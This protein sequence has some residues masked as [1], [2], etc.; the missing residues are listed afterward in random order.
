M[1]L[2]GGVDREAWYSHRFKSGQP[3]EGAIRDDGG[4]PQRTVLI[5]ILR[6]VSTGTDGHWTKGKFIMASDGHMHWWISQG[7][8][9]RFRNKA[10]YHFCEGPA[11]DCGA[12]SKGASIYLEKFRVIT[13][14]MVDKGSPGW[15]FGRDHAKAF[16]SYLG[17]R[18]NPLDPGEPK[19]DL[20]WG[21]KASGDKGTEGSGLSSNAGKEL[22]SRLKK[23]RDELKRLE[24]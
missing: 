19:A 5:E 2:A 9:A 1:W 14:K 3:I 13:Q 23:T 18:D 21:G 22:K 20:P 6:G 12:S 16:K 8:G 10:N 15:A 7:N 11:V 4:K 24:K 17:K